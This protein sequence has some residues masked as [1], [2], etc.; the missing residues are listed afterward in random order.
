MAPDKSFRELYI[1]NLDVNKVYFDF[2]QDL[3]Y[4]RLEM[5]KFTTENTHGVNDILNSSIHSGRNWNVLQET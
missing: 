3:N 2:A 5:E 1:P 4:L